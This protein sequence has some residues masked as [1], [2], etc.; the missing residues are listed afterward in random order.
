MCLKYEF[1]LVFCLF[2]FNLFAVL[3]NATASGSEEAIMGAEVTI[4]QKRN[5]EI[6]DGISVLSLRDDGITPYEYLDLH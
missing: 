2:V 6:P 4:E 3:S 5:G 1:V